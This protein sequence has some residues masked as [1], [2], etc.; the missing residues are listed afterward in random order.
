ML[1]PFKFSFTSDTKCSQSYKSFSAVY[2]LNNGHLILFNV[3][4]NLILDLSS[5]LVSMT[6]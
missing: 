1:L 4:M 5:S 3:N 2:M 6:S